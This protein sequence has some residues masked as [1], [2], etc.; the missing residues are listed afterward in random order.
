MSSAASA[1]PCY[2]RRTRPNPPEGTRPGRIH[3]RVVERRGG[4]RRGT[5][6]RGKAGTKDIRSQWLKREE[7]SEDRARV[8]R[9]PARRRW[10]DDQRRARSM[11]AGPAMNH[12]P[13][14]RTIRPEALATPVPT[15]RSESSALGSQE[16]GPHSSLFPLRSFVPLV[17]S[18][19]S[20]PGPPP[21][22]DCLGS[23]VS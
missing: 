9:A 6:G 4:A 17:P 21:A 18:S 1:R 10:L 22:G 11:D 20:S 16:R 2:Q 19:L 15:R 14:P 23:V 7:D 5:K 8:R 3:L 13:K 12:R